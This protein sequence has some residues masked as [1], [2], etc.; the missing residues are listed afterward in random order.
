[1][2]AG[3]FSSPVPELSVEE[4]GALFLKTVREGEIRFVGTVFRS[5]QVPDANRFRTPFQS[6]SRVLATVR[7]MTIPDKH[8]SSF[9]S[10]SRSSRHGGD[11]KPDFRLR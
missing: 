9:L 2:E 10:L 8:F 4:A 7:W 6:A 5:G 1:M 3:D 11:S